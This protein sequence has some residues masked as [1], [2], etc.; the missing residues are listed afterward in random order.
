MT[1]EREKE[2]RYVRSKTPDTD[3]WE[4]CVVDDLLSEIDR[5]RGEAE[6]ASAYYCRVI[7]DA[8]NE[9]Y[10]LREEMNKLRPPDEWTQCIRGEREI[11]WL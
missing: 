6:N 2:I 4:A 7:I 9:I 8:K 11:G 3:P 5:L 10:H 1:P